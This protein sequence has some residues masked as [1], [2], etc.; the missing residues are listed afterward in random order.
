M[1]THK[2]G[3]YIKQPRES[4]RA[5]GMQ[6]E[7]RSSATVCILKSSLSTGCIVNVLGRLTNVVNVLAS[8]PTNTD[9]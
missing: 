3:V 1:Y 2:H 6:E 5:E 7:V 8:S 4:W 9:F